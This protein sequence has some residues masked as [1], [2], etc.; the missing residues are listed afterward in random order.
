LG[1]LLRRSRRKG[2]KSEQQCTRKTAATR[3]KRLQQE[4]RAA[5]RHAKQ[6]IKSGRLS[7]AR[8]TQRNEKGTAC[9]GRR[10]FESIGLC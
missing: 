8:E 6:H 1:R 9:T 2:N 5:I 10:L 4:I 3:K 7:A